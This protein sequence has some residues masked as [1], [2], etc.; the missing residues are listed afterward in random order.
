[1]GEID[2]NW[3]EEDYLRKFD[4]PKFDGHV[5]VVARTHREAST[6][7]RNHHLFPKKWDF[8]EDVKYLKGID[9]GTIV[10]TG[11]HHVRKDIDQIRAEVDLLVA[12]KK[13]KVVYE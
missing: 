4:E 12:E 7:A 9:S 3:F 1:M 6:F 13:V 2:Q 10:F 5:Y 8:V 11:A